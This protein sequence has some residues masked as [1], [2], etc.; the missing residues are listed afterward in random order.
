MSRLGASVTGI[1]AAAE[2]IKAAEAHRNYD[3]A[4]QHNLQ[5]MNCTTDELIETKHNHFDCVVASEVVEHVAD[6]LLFVK[7]C[8]QL[9]KVTSSKFN[10][11]V[12]KGMSVSV[13]YLHKKSLK[14]CP[15]LLLC[16][17]LFAHS[18]SQKFYIQ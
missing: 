5:Y 18:F 12:L 17:I 10:I 1:D 7:S 15:T 6:P 11:I 4:L 3:P 8:S 16:L 2:N 13:S 14:Q 9:A